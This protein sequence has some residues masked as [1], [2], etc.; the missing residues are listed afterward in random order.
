MT[1]MPPS[2]FIFNPAAS[3]AVADTAA[4][5]AHYAHPAHAAVVPFSGAFDP[6]AW[7]AEDEERYQRF[8]RA[9]GELDEAPLFLRQY[10]KLR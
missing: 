6:E 1:F 8:K 4:A 10:R 5:S 9:V 2:P 3:D 7:T